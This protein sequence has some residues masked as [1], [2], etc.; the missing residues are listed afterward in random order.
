M[1]LN[2]I[3]F[4]TI[5]T[6]AVIGFQVATAVKR[7]SEIF[8]EFNQSKSVGWY[9]L[10]FPLGPI[11]YFTTV[12][13]FGWLPAIVLTVFC[14]LPALI[15]AKKRIAVFERAG[16]DRVRNAQNATTKAFGAAIAGLVFAAF[17][18]GMVFINNAFA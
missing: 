17:L 15:T 4:V 14:Y 11:I 10:L 3:I 7:E 13:R 1:I 6:F 18:L 9:S 5:I 2:L 16:T 8:Q 12:Y